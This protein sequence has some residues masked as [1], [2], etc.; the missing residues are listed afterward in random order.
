MVLMYIEESLG[1]FQ[2]LI[3]LELRGYLP[4][5]LMD[6]QAPKDQVLLSTP[7]DRQQ[8]FQELQEDRRAHRDWVALQTTMDLPISKHRPIPKEVMSQ[9]IEHPIHS[10]AHVQQQ[11]VKGLPV[12]RDHILQQAVMDRTTSKVHIS[13]RTV[14]GHIQTTLVQ[15]TSRDLVHQQ[16]IKVPTTSRAQ[17]PRQTI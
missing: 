10:K 2:I 8:A 7:F 16:T 4:H 13:Q 17:G 14:K 11:T 9:I 15:A 12:F 6:H 5:R 3:S 1:L